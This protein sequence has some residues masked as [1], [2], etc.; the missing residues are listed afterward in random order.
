MCEELT[1]SVEPTWIRWYNSED[2]AKIASAD[3]GSY[4]AI[5]YGATRPGE[6]HAAGKPPHP[7]FGQWQWGLSCSKASRVIVIDID[8]PDKWQ[9]GNAY[10][11]LGELNDIANSVREDAARAHVVIEVPEELLHLW[12]K[13]G[14]TV[15]GDVKSNGFSY[16]EGIHKSGIRYVSLDRPWVVA[17]AEILT[18]LTE[19]RIFPQGK[20][21]TGVMA[22]PWEDDSF[23]IE[24]HD[25]C[26]ATVMSMVS[27]GLTDDEVYARLE[28]IMPNRDGDWPGRDDYIAEKIRSAAHKIDERDAREQQWANEFSLAHSGR[29]WAEVLADRKLQAL[30][31]QNMTPAQRRE[32]TT[33]YYQQVVQEGRDLS[34]FKIADLINPRH[35][36]VEHRSVVD[37]RVGED[38]WEAASATFRYA[39]DEDA[40][41]Q[42]EGLCWAA[43]PKDW[44]PA[45]V[46]AW[47][48][49]LKTPIQL[50]EELKQAGV[51]ETE[52]SITADDK[53]LD[54]LKKS[55]ARLTSNSGQ[56][57]VGNQLRTIAR[58]DPRFSFRVADLD[59]EPDVLWAGGQPWS[60]LSPALTPAP[61]A[62]PV[63]L[64]T[65]A[66]FPVLGPTPA[67]D[68][69]LAA[70]WP[71]PEVRAWALR[72]IAAVTLWGDTSKMHPVLDGKPGA[73]KSTFALILHTILG[74]YSVKVSPDKILGGESGSGADEE[75]AAMIGARCVWMDEP[76]PGDKQAVS[77]FNDLASGTGEISAARKYHNRVSAPKRFN[78]LI[79]Q[80][81]R[82]ALRMD[83]QG[84]SERI[85]YIPCTGT[86]E[87]TAAAWERWCREGKDEYGAILGRLIYECALHRT[88]QAFPM[89]LAAQMGRTEAQDRS[90]EFATWL[91]D[92]YDLLPEGT[93]STDS[94]LQ[95]SPTCG[96]LRTQYNDGHARVNRLSML[97]PDDVKDQLTKLKVQVATAGVGNGRRKDVAFVRPTTR[98][99]MARF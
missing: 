32:D 69:V 29:T 3:V 85:T 23:R 45:I 40:Y 5:P 30:K 24:S 58:T 48:S 87:A 10:V 95:G 17:T 19:D 26:V 39:T 46:S 41:Y 52:E 2:G 61:Y 31:V 51:A 59:S 76:P 35:I 37:Q 57:A 49:D 82:N 16:V 54:R 7:E 47:S 28:L 9:Q 53:R 75:V 99:F 97:K 73:G 20:G 36:P 22:G 92:N 21:A 34:R 96:Q 42:Y 65:A 14:P 83:A 62:N 27:S 80:N 67:F 98:T 71:D 66:A 94:A 70:V 33:A 38:I 18:S 1:L 90:D 6:K 86:A 55:W 89:P 72:E 25:E 13:Q 81:P 93:K 50:E 8:H 63:H 4:E 44:G 68:Q 60:L 74:S 84:V 56:N 15:W 91:L 12:P 88:G 64:K 11:E 79:C 78:F 43:R 77:R